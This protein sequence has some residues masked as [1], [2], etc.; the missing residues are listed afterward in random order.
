MSYGATPDIKYAALTR[1]GVPASALPDMI[2]AFLLRET[3]A[4]NFHRSIPDLWRLY[5]DASWGQHLS[6]AK[7]AFFTANLAPEYPAFGN[8]RAEIE[9]AWWM[10]LARPTTPSDETTHD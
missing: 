7:H 5:V 2:R 1:A 8:S 9:Q 6:D 10:Q 3:G 4:E